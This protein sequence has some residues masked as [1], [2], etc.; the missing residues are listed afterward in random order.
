MMGESEGVK[1]MGKGDGKKIMG[2]VW[3][4]WKEMKEE[5]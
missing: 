3:G 4:V 2:K 1:E 5:K